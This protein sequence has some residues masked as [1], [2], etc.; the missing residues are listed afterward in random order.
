MVS[1]N[2]PIDCVDYILL[3]II[4]ANPRPSSVFPDKELVPCKDHNHGICIIIIVNGIPMNRTLM[5]IS[6]L[7]N[8][9]LI[10][11]LHNCGIKESLMAHTNNI[12]SAYDNSK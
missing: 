7:L 6:A 1:E 2:L 3:S 4:D 12:V 9:Y 11:T 10:S 8:V 5:D